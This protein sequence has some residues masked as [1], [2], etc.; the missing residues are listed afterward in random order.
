MPARRRALAARRKAVGHT[1]EQLA[2][3]LGV[4]RSTVVRW[5][6]GETEPL[7]RCRPQLAE[8]LAVS[9]DELDELLAEPEDLQGQP[10]DALLVSLLGD[11]ASAQ[12]GT[13][14]ER[15]AAMDIAS[16]RE[17]LQELT[18]MSGAI[19][20][21]PVRRAG[22]VHDGC[23]HALQPSTGPRGRGNPVKVTLPESPRARCVALAWCGW[24]RATRS[25][26][27]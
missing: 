19:L 13:L 25:A 5:E 12:V 21:Q 15:F 6:A 4:E 23:S 8:A 2:A 16:R 24:T 18:I 27:S 9:L 10:G 1:Q 7:P 17:V 14:M 22:G 11:V 3:L 26:I 20:L